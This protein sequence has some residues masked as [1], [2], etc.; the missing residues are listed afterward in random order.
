MRHKNSS[1]AIVQFSMVD[2]V[3]C[4]LINK[5]YNLNKNDYASNVKDDLSAISVTKWSK[6]RMT[7]TR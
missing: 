7:W 4:C 2:T 1:F 5:K 3:I 6:K